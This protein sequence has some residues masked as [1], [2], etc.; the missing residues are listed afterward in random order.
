[1]LDHLKTPLRSLTSFVTFRLAR[2]QNKLNA[3]AIFFL[4]S[5]CG[6]SLV[7]WRIIQLMR[8]FEGASMSKLAQ[9]VQIDKGQLSR[10]ISVMVS[11]G[12]VRT[13]PHETDHRQQK[14]S[15]TDKALDINAQMM[16][17]M[18]KR[19]DQLVAEVT[20][21]D[22]EVFFNVLTAIEKA[23]EFRDAP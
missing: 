22:L 18:Q 12:L 14:L 21:E 2:T 1:M 4:K 13:E 23:S 8:L 15:L 16:P 17:I 20:P 9:E 19:Q 10:K 7:E 5:E 11:K 3:Q 6:L